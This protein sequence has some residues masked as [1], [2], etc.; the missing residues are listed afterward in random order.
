VNQLAASDVAT[1]GKN[2]WKTT[3]IGKSIAESFTEKRK[4]SF[5]ATS[6]TGEQFYLG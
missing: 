5:Y 2:K 1:T 6:F 3:K 4:G